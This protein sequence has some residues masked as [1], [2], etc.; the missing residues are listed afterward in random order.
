MT[1]KNFTYLFCLSTFILIACGSDNSNQKIIGKWQGISW[2]VK[3]TE[4]G[5]NAV[6]VSFEF[7]AD[8]TYTAAFG[9]QKE[10]GSFHLSGDK[11]FTTAKGQAEKKVQ[12]HLV[13]VD[14]LV[15]DM[16]RAGTLE[17]LVLVKK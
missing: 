9:Q 1:I 15:M 10:E 16:N 8:N 14:T 7:K 17:E 2:K 6:D 4:S 11:L 13:A 12:V 3:G 5:R